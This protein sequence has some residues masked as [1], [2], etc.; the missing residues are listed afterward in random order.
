MPSQAAPGGTC[1][2]CL[3]IESLQRSH[4]IPRFVLKW[5]RETGARKF[6]GIKRPR[7]VIQDSPTR[8]LLCAQCEQRFSVWERWFAQH[9]LRRSPVAGEG[10]EYGSELY[11]F[12]L[13]VLWRIAVLAPDMWE[14]E[15]PAFARAIAARSE[16]WRRFLI[17]DSETASSLHLFVASR[18]GMALPREVPGF[19]QY[20]LRFSDGTLAGGKRRCYAFAKFAHFVVF[21]SVAGVPFDETV[22]ENTLVSPFGGRLLL[23]HQW[24]GDQDFTGMLLGRTEAL[25]AARQ[26]AGLPALR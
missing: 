3:R 14:V 17:G 12:G 6:Y 15:W 21:A 16:E 4:A 23:D 8:Y 26:A 7:Q 25:N 1:R 18:G 5:L 11:L 24:I 9:V 2:L 22:V 19:D 10:I 13:S 20:V